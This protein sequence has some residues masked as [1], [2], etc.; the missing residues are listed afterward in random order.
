[1]NTVFDMV[2]GQWQAQ[3]EAPPETGES[4]YDLREACAPRLS[5]HC[6]QPLSANHLPPVWLIDIDR[7]LG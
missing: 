2:S 6:E 1:M 7:M 4:F 3:R 5:E